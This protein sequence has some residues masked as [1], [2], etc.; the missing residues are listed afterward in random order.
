[1]KTK[2][3]F[4]SRIF[5]L[6]FI[7]ALALGCSKDG[8]D[9]AVGPQ[10]AQGIQGEPGPQGAQGEQGEQG[11]TGTANVI[12]S[13]W[14]NTEFGSNITE[15]SASFDIPVT[16]IDNEIL[17]F[18]T[19]LV[20]GSRINNNSEL[21]VYELPIVFGVA[22]QQSYYYQASNGNLRITVAANEEGEN[23]LDGD[24][25]EQYRYVIIP[26]GVQSSGKS[27]SINYGKMTYEEIV[28]HF[29]IP[30]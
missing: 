29:N 5:R 28:A 3:K 10:G 12:Y 11:E 26:G 22:R 4:T 8:N 27:S 7:A 23:V 15:A 13:N 25:L 2:M 19:L 30:R 1:M 24:F 16:E 17:N 20:Y 21:L 6:L 18:G 9:G 14:F